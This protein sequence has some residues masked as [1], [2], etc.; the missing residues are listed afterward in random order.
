MP[1]LLSHIQLENMR[2]VIGASLKKKRE[3]AKIT[4][5][6]LCEASGMS[7]LTLSRIEDGSGDYKIDNLSLYREGLRQMR[8]PDVREQVRVKAKEKWQ[9]KWDKEK[10]KRHE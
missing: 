7:Y 3:A 2:K 6:Q 10:S 5:I 1:Y 9:K 4:R 8:D